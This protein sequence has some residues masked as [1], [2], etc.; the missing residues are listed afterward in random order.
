MFQKYCSF[1]S[2]AKVL[3]LGSALE[4]DSLGSNCLSSSVGPWAGN[5]VSLG[6]SFLV[7]KMGMITTAPALCSGRDDVEKWCLEGPGHR[8]WPTGTLSENWPTLA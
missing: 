2:E 1:T 6:I 5:V 3:S 8:T 7:Y 4:P